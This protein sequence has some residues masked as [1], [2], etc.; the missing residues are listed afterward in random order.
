MTDDDAKSTLHRY[1]R[2][3]REAMVWKLDGLSEYDVRRPLTPTCTNLLWLVKHLSIVEA[4]YFGKTFDRPFAEDL[5]WWDE[6]AEEQIDMWVTAAETRAEIVDRYR[7]VRLHADVTINDL[8]ADAPGHVPW[9]PRPDV[10][11][12]TMLVHVLAETNRHAGHADILREQL[13]WSV[14]M[15]S[16]NSNVAEHGAAWWDDLRGRIEEAAQT[17]RS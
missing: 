3:A 9:W 8:P 2:Q 5:P 13:D 7:R 12:H 15:R 11:L 6:G 16:D 1:L 10:T 4:W 17:A 14:G